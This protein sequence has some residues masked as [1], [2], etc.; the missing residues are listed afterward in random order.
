MT[1]EQKIAQDKSATLDSSKGSYF[2]QIELDSFMT[3]TTNSPNSKLLIWDT[4]MSYH[5]IYNQNLIL[6]FWT[7]I[8]SRSV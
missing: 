1:N 6:K 8:N 4:G 2:I 3:I 7:M 5:S